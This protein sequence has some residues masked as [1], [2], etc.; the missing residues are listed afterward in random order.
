MEVQIAL[1]RSATRQ[2]LLTTGP[3]VH[4]GRVVFGFVFSV[5]GFAEGKGDGGF[6]YSTYVM[7]VVLNAVSKDDSCVVVYV[8]S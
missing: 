6:D 5:L 3:S 8:D 7:Y 2:F 1:F 4:T